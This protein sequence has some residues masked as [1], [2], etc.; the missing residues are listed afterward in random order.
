VPMYFKSAVDTLSVNMSGAACKYKYKYI[1]KYHYTYEYKCN[2]KCKFKYCV[3]QVPMYFKS[4]VDT[5][6]VNMSGAEAIIPALP[7]SVLLGCNI[8][9]PPHP[10]THP[11]PPLPPPF[12]LP[13]CISNVYLC[14]FVCMYACMD[15][16]PCIAPLRAT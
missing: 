3:T 15:Y 13:F 1:Y 8:P 12:P 16:H 7:L 2:Y 4:A 10:P 6:S 9:P 5:L 14:M 11:P